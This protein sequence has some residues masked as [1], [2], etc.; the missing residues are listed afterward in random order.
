MLATKESMTKLIIPGVL[1]AQNEVIQESK[2][3]HRKYSPYNQLK[4]A[5]E[6]VIVACIRNQGLHPIDATDLPVCV[7]VDW[8]EPSRRR[9]PDNI[10]CGV[11]MVLD[12]LVAA[13]ILPNDG[14]SEVGEMR[15][16]YFVDKLNPRVEVSLIPMRENI[17][18]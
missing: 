14:W 13:R 3:Q 8:Y 11:K 4:R 15:D 1:P 9:N 5:H 6:A 7:S 16:R 10:R 2:R 18:K 17:D 12:A